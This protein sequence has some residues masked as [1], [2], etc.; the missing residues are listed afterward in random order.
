MYLPKKTFNIAYEILMQFIQ[1]G[2][3]WQEYL[4]ERQRPNIQQEYYTK[5]SIVL[6]VKYAIE[7]DQPAQ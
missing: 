1:Y 5:S 7:H 6:S 3:K 2:L 4:H